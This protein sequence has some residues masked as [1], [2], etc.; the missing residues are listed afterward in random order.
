[1]G[2]IG[3]QIARPF[4]YA[5]KTGSSKTLETGRSNIGGQI[6]GCHSTVKLQCADTILRTNFDSHLRSIGLS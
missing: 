5:A 2:N 1:M 6:T 4:E 3:K